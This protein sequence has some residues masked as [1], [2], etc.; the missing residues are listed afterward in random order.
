MLQDIAGEIFRIPVSASGVGDNT[1]VAG[2][3]GKSIY[4]YELI[5]SNSLAAT[6]SVKNG[7]T[8]LDT[9]SLQPNQGVTWSVLGNMEGVPRFKTA[10]GSS[11]ILNLSAGTFTGGLVYAFRE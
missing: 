3:A 2:Q 10:P 5:G 9:Q 11:F 8:I 6:V 7:S 4:V 1:L